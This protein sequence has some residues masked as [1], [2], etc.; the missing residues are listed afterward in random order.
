MSQ[1]S[2]EDGVLVFAE[3]E[4]ASAF[5]RMLLGDQKTEL[6]AE[7]VTKEEER[8]VAEVVKKYTSKYVALQKYKSTGGEKGTWC[9]SGAGE[10]KCRA[11][12]L[13]GSCQVKTLLNLD[14]WDKTKPRLTIKF[15][16]GTN[17]KKDHVWSNKNSFFRLA[18]S[19]AGDD[20]TTLAITSRCLFDT[21]IYSSICVTLKEPTDLVHLAIICLSTNLLGQ[22]W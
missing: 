12:R 7:I 3:G 8:V 20:C 15:P 1:V 9:N 13:A 11:G 10:E 14:H 2:Q 18:F 21:N 16:Q 5:G 4:V 17:Q 22:K 6:L 19:L